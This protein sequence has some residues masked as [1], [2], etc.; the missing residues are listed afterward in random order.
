MHGF[1]SKKNT[2]WQKKKSPATYRQKESLHLLLQI[3][4]HGTEK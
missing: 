3:F 4:R 1:I 2:N